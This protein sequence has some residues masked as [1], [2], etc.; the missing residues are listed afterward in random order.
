MHIGPWLFSLVGIADGWPVNRGGAGILQPRDLRVIDESFAL[1]HQPA[2][3]VRQYCMVVNLKPVRAIILPGKVLLFPRDG[4]DGELLVR[5]LAVAIFTDAVALNQAPH[6]W[7]R[8]RCV[9]AD[10][11]CFGFGR[12]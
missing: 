2:F 3:L 9:G 11:W 4:A 5:T 8:A 7:L 10:C 12:A 1:S 6:A